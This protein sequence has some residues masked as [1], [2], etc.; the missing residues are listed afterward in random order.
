MDGA[1]RDGLIDVEVAVSDLE[2]E[3]A[4]WVRADPGFVVD[5]S[6]LTAEV[7]QRNQIAS[8]ALLALGQTGKF[9]DLYHPNPAATAGIFLPGIAGSIAELT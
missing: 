3:A 8:L 5:G 2:I 1:I 9:H 6:A 4:I 7:R